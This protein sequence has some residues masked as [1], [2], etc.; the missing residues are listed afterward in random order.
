V[1]NNDAREGRLKDWPVLVHG[2]AGRRR[3]KFDHRLYQ[4][5][6]NPWFHGHIYEACLA[7]PGWVVMHDSVLYFLVVGLYRDRPDFYQRLFRLGGANAI[8]QIKQL[9]RARE[10]LLRFQHPERIPLNTELL[11]SGNRIVV[12]SEH[13]RFLVH[14]S[15]PGVQVYRSE[16]VQASDLAP[17]KRTRAEV[18]ATMDI[19]PE[20]IV[21]SSLGFVAPTKLNDVA[22]RVVERVAESTDAPLYYLM[23]GEGDCVNR[24]LGERIKLTGY[25]NDQKFDEYLSYSDLVLNLRYPVMGEASAALL[26][27]F[28]CERPCI[29][30]DLGWFSELP[31]NVVLKIDATDVGLIENYLFEALCLYLEYPQPFL[32]MGQ[33]AR[34]YVRTR[35]SP[36]VVAEAYYQL[37]TG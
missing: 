32:R 29:V 33:R 22:C 15:A 23:V 24:Y 2:R 11:R 21:V 28:A 7:D 20:A 31:D 37:L 6:N 9:V 19:P 27:A 10:D 30:T 8:A 36:A 12:H 35:H 25:V 1:Q 4:I 16:L 17:A 3:S 5:G 34:C 26:R 18:L 13:T 14:Q